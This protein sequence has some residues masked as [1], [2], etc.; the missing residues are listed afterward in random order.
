MAIQQGK[1]AGTA[2]LSVDG[3]SYLLQADLSW[4]VASVKRETMTGMDGI[5]GFKETPIPGFI[6]ATLRDTSGLSV[7]DFNAMEDTTVNLQL[8]NGKNV[9]GRNMW[10]V[11]AQEVKSTEA[12]FE[13]R[14]EGPFVEEF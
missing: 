10:T 4:G 3:V 6:A 5:H 9:I 14:W 12:T 7:A 1:L 11:E 8:A 2:F 13:V